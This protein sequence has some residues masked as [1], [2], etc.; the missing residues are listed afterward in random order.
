MK[1][2]LLI[3]GLAMFLANLGAEVLG[4]FNFVLGSVEYKES[5]NSSPKTASKNMPVHRDGYLST[6]LAARAEI[7]FS[8]GS[9]AK[10]EQNKKVSIRELFAESSVQGS[11]SDKMK[12]QLK[13]ITLP[14]KREATTV[15][16]IRRNEAVVQKESDYYW[17]VEETADV[18]D[19]LSLLERKQYREAIAIFIQVIEQAPLLRE[20]EISHAALA[21][22]Y[23]EQDNLSARDQ[24]LEYLSRDFPHSK[25]LMDSTEP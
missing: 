9:I 15:A 23:A 22:I 11:W 14:Q 18:Q 8:N 21:I 24:H 20:A 2:L 13:S 7:L 16:G 3:I 5:Q 6:A 25:F 10:V 1:H 17:E 12:R 19:A 4:S